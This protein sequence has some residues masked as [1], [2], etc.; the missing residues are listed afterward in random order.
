MTGPS[1]DCSLVGAPDGKID[2]PVVK[3]ALDIARPVSQ[4]QTDQ[5]ADLVSL[6]GE[7]CNVE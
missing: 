7:W 3:L 5:S 2:V 1:E 4:I 6:F